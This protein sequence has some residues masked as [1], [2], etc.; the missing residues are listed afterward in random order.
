MNV[1]LCAIGTRGDVQPILALAVELKS[2]GHQARLCVAPDYKEW[3]ESFGVDCSSIWPDTQVTSKRAMELSVEQLGQLA[4]QS[5]HFEFPAVTKAACGCDVIIAGGPQLA[6]RS[7]AEALEIP[8]VFAAYCPAVLP[9]RD[10][11]PPLI[12]ARHHPQLLPAN[13]SGT[14]WEEDEQTWNGL[15]SAVVNEERARA[16]LPPI[17]SVQ[18]HMFTD[19]PWLAADADLAPA[20]PSAKMHIFQTGAWLLINPEPLPEYVDDFL[21]DGEPPVYFG[22]G[23]M[24]ALEDTSQGMIEA[25]RALGLRSI[26]ARGQ[27]GLRPIDADSDCLFIGDTA[28]ERLLPRVAAIVHH[29][30]AGT[31]TAA[32]MAGKPQLIVPHMYDQYYWAHR[33]EQLGIGIAGPSRKELSGPSI[34]AALQECMGEGI[35]LRAETLATRVRRHGAQLAVERLTE[36]FG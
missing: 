15:F 4:A 29:G 35:T 30:G 24:P 7:V 18:R 28:H 5:V 19:N 17:E 10:H 33:V 2:R 16:G 26:V 12:G 9:S 32:A 13:G 1:L 6:T 11:P 36:E 34:T 31:T 3:V 22:F 23:S 25:A 8:Y 20:A 27:G 14:L 21:A